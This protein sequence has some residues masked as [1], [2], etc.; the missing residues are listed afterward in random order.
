[1]RLTI[2]AVAVRAALEQLGVDRQQRRVV[3]RM[4]ELEAA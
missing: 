2:L 1:M 4:R 3:Q